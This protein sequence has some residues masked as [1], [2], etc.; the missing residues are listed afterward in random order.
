VFRGRRGH[1]CGALRLAVRRR[2]LL[3]LLRVLLIS[4]RLVPLISHP[5]TLTLTYLTSTAPSLSPVHAQTPQ[6]AASAPVAGGL[7]RLLGR[8]R[9][10]LAP[11]L[12]PPPGPRHRHYRR[13]VRRRPSPRGSRRRRPP[14][15]AAAAAAIISGRRGGGGGSRG[16]A[17]RG[18]DGGRLHGACGRA[19]ALHRGTV[20]YTHTAISSPSPRHITSPTHCRTQVLGY[21]SHGTT[22]LR[23]SLHGRPVAV[24]RMLSRFNRAA[25]REVSLLI[26]SDGHPNVV[27]YFCR[28]TRQEFVYLALQVGYT[29]IGRYDPISPAYPAPYQLLCLC[30]LLWQLCS[31]SLRDFVVRLQQQGS[32]RQRKPALTSGSADAADNTSPATA[33]TAS[34]APAAS[35]G[36][37]DAARAALRQIADGLAHL[38]AQRIVHRD[39]KVARRALLSDALSYHPCLVVHLIFSLCRTLQHAA[40]QHPLRAARATDAI[41]SQRLKQQVASRRRRRRRRR[42]GSSVRRVFSRAVCGQRRRR[43]RLSR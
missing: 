10:T 36:I 25:D 18:R 23:G 16:G 41:P 22:V 32:E 24:K 30:L 15:A 43:D 38:H 33:A 12:P 19:A 6:R 8:G 27:R 9:R 37:S 2:A 11:Q 34:A 17:E 20:S 29:S 39:I 26:R 31:M 35:A 14:A 28:E 7:R 1:V 3:C 21:G 4:C 5:H 13:C 42:A 40:P